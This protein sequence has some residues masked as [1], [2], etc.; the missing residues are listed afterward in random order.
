MMAAAMTKI[1]LVRAA[2]ITAAMIART[3]FAIGQMAS[4]MRLMAM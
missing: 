1:F 4:K 3:I 2:A